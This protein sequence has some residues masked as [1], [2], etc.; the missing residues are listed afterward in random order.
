MGYESVK[1]LKMVLFESLGTVSYSAS[2][3]TMAVSLAISKIFSVKKWPDLEI[4]V[5]GRSKS[6]K[7]ARSIDHL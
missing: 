6:S 7:M 4:L 1:V 3:L 2:I 5:R